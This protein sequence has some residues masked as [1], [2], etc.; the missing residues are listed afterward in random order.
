[1]QV[2]ANNRQAAPVIPP[3]IISVGYRVIVSFCF[4]KPLISAPQTNPAPWDT[5][6]QTGRERVK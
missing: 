1:M 5:S 2:V 3:V 6:T 4:L